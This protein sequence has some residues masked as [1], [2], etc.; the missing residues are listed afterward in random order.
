VLHRRLDVV[1]AHPLPDPSD[2]G[3]AND[4][5][6]EGVAKVVEAQP[7]ERRSLERRAIALGQR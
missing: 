1:V 7:P 3:E 2:V 6:A 5:R 4:A